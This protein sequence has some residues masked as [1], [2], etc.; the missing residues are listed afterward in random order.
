MAHQPLY[1]Y[2]VPAFKDKL[3]EIVDLA[4]P[5]SYV[6]GTGQ[7]IYPSLFGWGGFDFVQAMNTG[8]VSVNQAAD[9]L[10]VDMSRSGTYFITIRLSTTYACGQAVKS[11]TIK[12]YNVADFA[13]VTNATDL[14]AERVRLMFIG[15]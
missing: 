11:V 6:N 3:T 8:L 10:V 13:E 14:S 4:G 7:I 9:Y 12:W 5:A 15:V 1:G 2:P